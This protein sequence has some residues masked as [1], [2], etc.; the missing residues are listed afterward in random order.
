MAP[1][2]RFRWVIAGL[3][4]IASALSFFDRQVLSVLAPRILQDLQL[5]NVEYSQ[6]VSAFTL[7]Y[8]VMFTVGG[9]LIDWAGT[10]MGLGSALPSGLWP[11]CCMAQS[12]AA[13]N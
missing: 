4:F 10:R 2:T 3:L 13:R 6:A 12:R 11:A 7:A 8:G 1:P 9:R 5:T